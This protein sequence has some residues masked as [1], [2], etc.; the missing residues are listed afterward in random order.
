M[1][2]ERF[3]PMIR[4]IALAFRTGTIRWPRAS[5]ALRGLLGIRSGQKRD[6]GSPEHRTQTALQ[7]ALRDALGDRETG[8]WRRSRTGRQRLKISAPGTSRNRGIRRR[9]RT[10]RPRLKVSA[11][12]TSRD[13]G[14]RRRSRTGRQRL[15]V[16]ASRAGRNRGI[17][18]HDKTGPLRRCLRHAAAVASAAD[19]A[20]TVV[21]D[22]VADSPGV[23]VLN[24]AFG[25]QLSFPER[26][27]SGSFQRGFICSVL[28]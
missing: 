8:T 5:R 12:R 20:P 18:H 2:G 11:S 16:S 9:S 25:R 17:R 7:I 15:K 23:P 1:K 27:S 26:T 6:Q 3:G 10:G 4:G 14:I 19:A 24:D 13:R 28:I 21:A 22:A